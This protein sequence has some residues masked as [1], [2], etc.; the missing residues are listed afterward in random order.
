MGTYFIKSI[1]NKFFAGERKTLVAF[2]EKADNAYIKA[3]QYKMLGDFTEYAVPEVLLHCPAK[4][5]IQKQ[6]NMGHGGT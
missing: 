2:L 3:F 6:P 5:N 1:F 4:N